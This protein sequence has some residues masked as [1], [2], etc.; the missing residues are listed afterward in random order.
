MTRSLGRTG[1]GSLAAA[2]ALS[3]ALVTSAAAQVATLSDPAD[4]PEASAVPVSLDIDAEEAMLDWAQCMRD[5]G[6]E[7]DDPQFG[8]EGGRLGFGAGGGEPAFDLRSSD[9]QAAMD[10]CGNVL[11]AMRPDLDAAEQ[12]ERAEQQL[13]IAGCMRDL[14]WDFPDP[15]T[16][17]GFGAQIRFLEEAGIDP[18]D[19]SFQTDITSCQAE[20]GFD[21]GRPGSAGGVAE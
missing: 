21:F 12:A 9:F 11:E 6:I 15:A 2:S 10:S 1:L 20:A 18:Q 14:G 13:A 5:N 7:I 19:P 8:A 3:L 17:G 4:E 16:G